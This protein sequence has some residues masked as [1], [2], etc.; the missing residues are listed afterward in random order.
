MVYKCKKTISLKLR[1]RTTRD[2]LRQ[3]HLFHS[4]RIKVNRRLCM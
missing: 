1:V 3:L 4:T 2:D